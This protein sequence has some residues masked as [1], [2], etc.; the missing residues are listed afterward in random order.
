VGDA[1]DVPL[2][3]RVFGIGC[4]LAELIVGLR[5]GADRDGTPP[6]AQQ[7][8][9]QLNRDFGNL[10]EVLQNSDLSLAE[11]LL[12]PVLARFAE[13]LAA[14][15]TFRTELAA[16]CD[17]LTSELRNLLNPAPCGPSFDGDDDVPF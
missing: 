2:G 6:E 17:A 3:V 4:R 1:A 13:S 16:Q 14:A 11:A 9:D 7:H 10:R 12:D 5:G 8:I 15:A